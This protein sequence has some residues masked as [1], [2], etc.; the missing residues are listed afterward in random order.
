MPNPS[1]KKRLVLVGIALLVG[2]LAGG[3]GLSNSAQPTAAPMPMETLP[4]QTSSPTDS[5]TPPPPSETPPPPTLTPTPI[6][7]TGAI[8]LCAAGKLYKITIPDKTSLLAEDCTDANL[9]PDGSRLAYHE[10]HTLLILNTTTNETS[11]ITMP[12]PDTPFEGDPFPRFVWS[13][14]SRRVAFIYRY[15]VSAL[16]LYT[17]NPEFNEALSVSQAILGISPIAWTADG[18]SLAFFSTDAALEALIYVFNLADSKPV[19]L[20]PFPK[21]RD[22]ILS[23]TWSPDGSKL[24]FTNA[25]AYRNSVPALYLIGRDGSGL[26]DLAHRATMGDSSWSPDGQKIAFCQGEYPDNYQVIMNPDGTD[27]IDF[28]E[29]SY[30]GCYPIFSPSGDYVLF[31][32]VEKINDGYVNTMYSYA[33]K[34]QEHLK[35]FSEDYGPWV[36]VG[37]S[38]AWSPDGRWIGFI[39]Q[40]DNKIYLIHP[41]GSGLTPITPPGP[42]DGQVRLQWIG[43]GSN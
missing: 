38:P 5:P 17:T 39:S 32:Q 3:C 11:S 31:D 23:L 28:R 27:R 4:S 2:L 21:Q 8:A 43:P 37:F 42:L 41:D 33:L 19:V 20:N 18:Q 15:G 35:L 9:S 40:K 24:L 6:G 7:G 30:S 10:G 29:K 36:S 22:Q 16:T 1:N 34:S 14:D 26:T 13:P 12:E 25:G